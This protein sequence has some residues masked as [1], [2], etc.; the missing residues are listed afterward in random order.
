MKT[1]WTAG[2]SAFALFVL[3]YCGW[4]GDKE[5]KEDS[6][7]RPVPEAVT[8][9]VVEALPKW[10]ITEIERDDDL[11]RVKL[12]SPQGEA[13]VRVNADGQLRSVYQEMG[14]EDAPEKVRRAVERAF[15]GGKVKETRKWTRIEVTYTVEVE[16]GGRTREVKINSE[17]RILEVERK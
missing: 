12:R 7:A 15:R 3:A 8:N 4:G 16:K 14:H 2:L 13:V 6:P 5:E 1:R 11:Y 9:T 17:G 10:V